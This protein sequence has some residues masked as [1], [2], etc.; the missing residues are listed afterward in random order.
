MQRSRSDTGNE[1]NSTV[2]RNGGPVVIVEPE[3]ADPVRQTPM[4]RDPQLELSKLPI[5]EEDYEPTHSD[6]LGRALRQLF[7]DVP[8]TAV[9]WVWKR[10]LALDAQLDTTLSDFDDDEIDGTDEMT[11]RKHTSSQTTETIVRQAIRDVLSE[12]RPKTV[13]QGVKR[14]R[15][16]F[17][18]T[19]HFNSWGDSDDPSATIALSDADA[20]MLA[21]IR[22][23]MGDDELDPADA[24]ADEE[25]EEQG[26]RK[27]KYNMAGEDGM[28]LN[29]MAKMLGMAG[30][31]G[32]KNMLNRIDSKIVFFAS[33][34]EV[35]FKKLMLGL[36]NEYIDALQESL[37][38]DGKLTVED[39]DFLDDLREDPEQVWSSDNFR[40]WSKDFLADLYKNQRGP[41]QR[42]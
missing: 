23:Q 6:E 2:P 20:D 11:D 33:L 38:E 21:A 32:V 29:D 41:K 25:E 27:A 8:D 15:S 22:K 14:R 18:P 36:A 4:L 17:E 5:D 35:W 26:K 28:T 30:P 12:A 31:S 39:R 3:P 10:A 13:S 9:P 1:L 24:V 42:Q 19:T 34:D 7:S 40:A 37:E 16:N